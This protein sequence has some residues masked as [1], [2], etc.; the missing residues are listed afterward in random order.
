[1]NE[2]EAGAKSFYMVGRLACSVEYFCEVSRL[3]VF[4]LRPDIALIFVFRGSQANWG[5]SFLLLYIPF[6][7]CGDDEMKCDD[8]EMKF[9]FCHN[10]SG[11]LY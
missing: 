8:D 2:A 11:R 4:V 7:I 5:Q 10:N 3:G 1:M 9:V 6:V